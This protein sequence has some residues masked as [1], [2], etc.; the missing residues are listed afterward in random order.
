MRYRS[1]RFASLAILLAALLAGTLA[2]AGP[3]RSITFL[4]APWGVPPDKDLLGKFTANTRIEVQLI[5]APSAEMYTKVQVASTARRAPAD[6]IVV[7]GCR[8]PY[9]VRRLSGVHA[10]IAA[11]GY[12]PPSIVA[13][14]RVLFGEIRAR[15]A[16]P[17]S[18]PGL[19]P[20]GWS[21]A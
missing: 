1:L 8:D 5:S 10:Y 9:E 4:T 13:A 2:A 7:L 14:V 6:V 21:G 11:M 12:R 15:G 16:L 20:L 19:Y 17:V 3:K 18:V